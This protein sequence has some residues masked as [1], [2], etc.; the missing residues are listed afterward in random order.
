[1]QTALSYHPGLVMK[2]SSRRMYQDKAVAALLNAGHVVASE[3]AGGLPV[4]PTAG[5][6]PHPPVQLDWKDLEIRR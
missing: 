1:M 2:T 3:R 6:C 5:D 4:R